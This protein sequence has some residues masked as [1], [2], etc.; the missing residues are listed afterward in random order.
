[1]GEHAWIEDVYLVYK[2]Y[3]DGGGAPISLYAGLLE[4]AGMNGVMAPQTLHQYILNLRVPLTQLQRNLIRRANFHGEKDLGSHD[5][6]EKRGNGMQREITIAFYTYF[7]LFKKEIL[8]SESRAVLGSA[9]HIFTAISILF[10]ESFAQKMFELL[11]GSPYPNY[12]SKES[13]IYNFCIYTCANA[14]RSR[15]VNAEVTSI[16]T[17]RDTIF[18]NNGQIQI[19]ELKRKRLKKPNPTSEL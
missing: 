7:W 19:K 15:S 17:Q 6:I 14:Q 2:D 18:W 9:L 13:D 8:E 3:L 11:N 4:E 5:I 1:M 12:Y 16:M 10:G